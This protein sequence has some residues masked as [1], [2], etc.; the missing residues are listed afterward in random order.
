MGKIS[1]DVCV[2]KH[3][4]VERGSIQRGRGAEA[5]WKKEKVRIAGERTRATVEDTVD[6]ERD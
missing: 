1:K 4:S 3:V 6:P 5:P 2:R